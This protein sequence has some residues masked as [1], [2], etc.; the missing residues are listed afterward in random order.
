ISA[1]PDYFLWG[2]SQ[3]DAAAAV[4]CPS[5]ATIEFHSR[6]GLRVN[7]WVRIP[8]GVDYSLHPRRL[9]AP[10]GGALVIGFVGTLLQHKG[11]H[12]L[13]E[14]VRLLTRAKVRLI[15]YGE[16]FHERRYE[17][18]LRRLAADD[19]RIDFAGPYEHGGFSQVL[20]PLDAVAI[21]S[22]WH[23]NIP[24]AGLNAVAAGG[25]LLVSAVPG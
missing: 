19:L 14:A 25:P 22:L 23:E 5:N 6:Q 24:I 13:V 21:P 9:P 8:W 17:Q 7:H 11:P 18:D 3:L 12:V 4:V 15:L 16:S 10:D 20:A 1:G 2:T